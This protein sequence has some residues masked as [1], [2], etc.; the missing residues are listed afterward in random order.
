MMS[1]S[2]YQRFWDGVGERF[3]DVLPVR[4]GVDDV[5]VAVHLRHRPEVQHPVE[6]DR[7]VR[8]VV[9]LEVGPEQVVELEAVVEPLRE[10]GSLVIP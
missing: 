6:V 5:E 1:R 3:H 4:R 9:D 7:R 8:V 10:D 2:A